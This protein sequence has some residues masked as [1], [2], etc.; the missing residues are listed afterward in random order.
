MPLYGNELDLETTPVR[1][2]PGT[3]RQARQAR[4]L[5]RSRGAG[6][7]RREMARP[8]GWSGSS[9]R[10]AASPGTAIRSSSA[11]GGPGVVTSGTQS[12]TLGV[13][14][15]MAY[16]A[17]ADAE[18]GTICRRRDPRCAGPRARSSTC[19]STGARPDGQAQ[20]SARPGPRARRSRRPAAPGGGTASDGP[21]R[22]ALHEGPRMGPAST[23]TRPPSGSPPTPPSSSATSSSSSC[24]T[25]GKALEQF[26]TFGVVESVKAVSDLFA[27]VGGEVVAANDA[28]AGS[29]E[30]V[31]SD[32]YG[33]GWMVRVRLADARQLD[34]LLDGGRL[35]R[36]DR[37]RLNVPMPYGPHTASDRERMLAALGLTSVDQL[38]DDIPEALR[39][40]RLDLPPPEPELELAARLRR[41][42]LA[43]GPTSPRSSAPASTATGARRP[44]TSSC[45]AVSGTPPTRRTSRR[46]ARARSRAST[47]TSR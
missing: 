16:V 15:A 29:P 14:I 38:F 6:T 10:A 42:P 21:Q 36:P 44:S 39:A 26:A 24:R 13:P 28:L 27:P 1:R 40:T 17:P 30:L 47:S 23:A 3:R 20:T 31:N 7:G 4:R 18:P 46:S 9:S 33:D 25:S 2:R 37:G 19:R 11:T 34:G 41:S 32:P 12:P 35:R 43:T 5:R 8:S 45:S 22:P